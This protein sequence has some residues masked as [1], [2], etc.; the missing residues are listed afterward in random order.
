[1]HVV[2]LIGL[3]TTRNT[4]WHRIARLYSPLV[5][6]DSDIWWRSLECPCGL[7]DLG[8]MSSPLEFW[9]T[10]SGSLERTTPM[11]PMNTFC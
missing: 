4:R 6:A 11:V 8:A 5:M 7:A 3:S 1:M 9:L 10:S 2:R